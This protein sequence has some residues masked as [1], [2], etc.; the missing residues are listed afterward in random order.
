MVAGRYE[1]SLLMFKYFSTLE[2]K[3]GISAR[4][5]KTCNILYIRTQVTKLPALYVCNALN[6]G[7]YDYNK[8]SNLSFHLSTVTLRESL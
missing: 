4:P 7:N 3:F 2:E 8:T 1:I 6:A 5:C